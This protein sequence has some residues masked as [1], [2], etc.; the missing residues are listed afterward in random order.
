MDLCDRNYAFFHM[1]TLAVFENPYSPFLKVGEILRSDP[2]RV[3][4]LT[5]AELEATLNAEETLEFVQRLTSRFHEV[6]HYHDIAL[7]RFGNSMFRK[8][9]SYGVTAASLAAL[10]APDTEHSLPLRKEDLPGSHWDRIIRMRGDCTSL[11]DSARLTLETSAVLLQR[12]LTLTISD[13]LHDLLSRDFAN[14][15][16]YGTFPAAFARIAAVADDATPELGVAIHRL[17]IATLCISDPAD[18]GDPPDAFLVKMLSG[19]LQ[20]PKAELQRRFIA[21]LDAQWPQLE[22]SMDAADDDNAAAIE[23]LEA[24]VEA[25]AWNGPLLISMRLAGCAACTFAATRTSSSGC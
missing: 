17:L 20:S 21:P 5:R 18:G 23:M 6:K 24:R 19:L 25:N 9:L 11:V 8:W 15:T 12:R 4:L 1:P 7:T 3:L 13:H 14:Q 2:E 16:V 10:H 22:K